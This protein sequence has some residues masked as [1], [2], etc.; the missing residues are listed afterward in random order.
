MAQLIA[1]LLC[2][3]LLVTLFPATAFAAFTA[4]EP[5]SGPPPSQNS[6][7]E[8]HP[9]HDETCGYTPAAEG[10]SCAFDCEICGFQNSSETESELQALKTEQEQIPY[11]YYTFHEDSN[12]LESQTG[13][14]ASAEVITET[15]TSWGSSGNSWYVVNTSVTISTRVTVTGSVHLILMDNT[16]L[17]IEGGIQVEDPNSLTIYGQSGGTGQLTAT[18]SGGAAAGIGGDAGIGGNGGNGGDGGNG[19]SVTIHGGTVTAI[20]GS[21]KNGGGAGIGGGGGGAE[22]YHTGYKGGSSQSVIIYGGTVN[23]TGGNSESNIIYERGGGGA[24]IGG[25]GGG[26]SE[27][28]TIGGTVLIYSGTVNATGGNS[29]QHDGG[30]GI[31]GSQVTIYNGRVDAIGGSATAT[32]SGSRGIYSGAGIG[33]DNSIVTIHD[34]TVNAT[35]GSCSFFGTAGIGG[36]DSTVTIYDGIVTADGGKSGSAGIGGDNSTVT[37]YDGT[38]TAN[39]GHA[40]DFGGGAGIGGSD[41]GS[42]KSVIINGGTVIAIGGYGYDNG[43]G[44]GIGGGGGGRFG[45]NGGNADSVTINGG[46]VTATGGGRGGAGIGGGGGGGLGGAALGGNVSNVTITGGTVIATG[47][48]DG[49]TG[50]GGGYGYNNGGDAGSVTISGGIV[51]AIGTNSSDPA[52]DGGAGIGGGGHWL[53]TGSG[54]DAGSVTISGGIVTAIS[55]QNSSPIGDTS[56]A[57]SWNG[58]VF[59]GD[60][61]QVYGD[62]TLPGDLTIEDNQTLTIPSEAILTIPSGS[63]LTNYGTLNN[64]GTLN[65]SGTLNNYG[66]LTGTVSGNAPPYIITASLDTGTVNTVYHAALESD[67]IATGWEI[68]DGILPDGLSLNENTISGTPT[69]AGTY[70]F[71]VKAT[72]SGGSNSRQLSI[73]IDSTLV[74]SVTLDRTNLSL[75]TGHATTLTAAVEPDDATN[76]NVS[77]SCSP[78]GIVAITPD[79]ADSRK[80]NIT[81]LA[82]GTATITV[83]AADGSGKSASCTVTV[84]SP[85]YPVTGITLDQTSLSLEKGN[86]ATLH[87]TVTPS[88][89]TNPTVTWFSSNETVAAV[90]RTGKVTAVGGG[91]AVITARAGSYSVSCTVTVTVPATGLTLDQTAFSLSVGGQGTLTA[92]LTPADATTQEI[93]WTSSDPEVAAVEGS[94]TEAAES[95]SAEAGDSSTASTD[96]REAG[97]ATVTAIGKGTAVITAATADGSL[98]ASCTVTVPAVPSAT[99]LTVSGRTTSSVTLSWNA[100]EEAEGYTIWYRS[101]HETSVT[102]KIIWDGDTTTWTKTGLEPG[103]KYFFAIRSWVTDADGNY[104][105][106]EVSPTQRGTTKPES[107]VIQSATVTNG[108]VKVRLAGEA[109]GARRYSI[110]YADSRNGFTKNDFQVGI[111]TSYTVRTMTPQLEP[112]TYYICVKSYR[113]LGNSKRI[114]GDWSNIVRVTVQ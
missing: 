98:A 38:V 43:G 95:S 50:I 57:S 46:N 39:G 24:G 110:C 85:Y 65:N 35:S 82:T 3:C 18:G 69:K 6:L 97:T 12:I 78:G 107:A 22:S 76:K 109:E 83:T 10:T 68:T 84:S 56:N 41:E 15:S 37:I 112:G 23:A 88:Y 19:G 113:D 5:D 61:G 8:H 55:G 59:Q 9:S 4:E 36:N 94:S 70:A 64:N 81:A 100:V 67:P 29:Y 103:T 40:T 90:D 54:G 11:I 49:G 62:Q 106:S 71:T 72:N 58:I 114:Y 79:P 51:T 104:V 2:L 31:G 16:E 21:G 91:T 105:F 45:G 92:F 33:G 77:W 80:A 26:I 34:G 101:E 30:S 73:T 86:T 111:R 52:K 53:S 63:T 25:G 87:A 99:A 32:N 13:T 14:A 102:R 47:G 60:N 28:N 96:S 75:T 89:A 20:G 74:T 93:L 42:S 66:T 108:Y 27:S 17:T 48:S 1:M 7:C 44:A